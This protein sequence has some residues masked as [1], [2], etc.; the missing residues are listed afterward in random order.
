MLKVK[1]VMNFFY[2]FRFAFIGVAVV[3]AASIIT[4]DSLK[5]A[6]TDVSDF[7]VVYTYGE[8]ISY[9]GSAIMGNVTFEFRKAGVEDWSEEE[10]YLVGKY[11]ARARTQGN[12]GYKY[13]DISTFEIKPYPVTIKTDKSIDFGKRP[14]FDYASLPNG[15]ELN[16]K[17][18]EVTYADLTK[19]STVSSIDKNSLKVTS[20]DGKDVTYCYDFTVEDNNITF[21]QAPLI[22]NFK[23]DGM[24]T[25]TGETF[26]SNTISSVILDGLQVT[27]DLYYDAH[28]E[29]VSGKSISTIGSYTN[30]HVIRIVDDE[31]NDYTANYDYSINENH[32]NIE[33]APAIVVTSNS[34]EKPYDGQ[35][36][37]EFANPESLYSYNAEDLIP[38]HKLKFLGFANANKYTAGTYPNDFDF[39]IVDAITEEPVNRELYKGVRKQTG[40]LK[41]NRREITITSCASSA[42]F[43]NR[44]HSM[45]NVEPVD[46]PIGDGPGLVAGDEIVVNTT[47]M[48]KVLEP[49]EGTANVLTYTINRGGDD[50]TASYNITPIYKNIT[51]TVTPLKF[52]FIERHPIYDGGTHPYYYADGNFDVYDSI[53]RRENAALLDETFN[54]L[55]AGWAYDVRIPDSFRMQDVTDS[56]GYQATV[57]DVQI[58]IYDNS[59]PRIEVQKYYKL[60]TDITFDIPVSSIV[61]ANLTVTVEDYN[62]VFDNNSIASGIITNPNDP[63]SCV[64]YNGLA[65]TDTPNVEFADATSTNKDVGSYNLSMVFGVKRGT[66]N[67][68]NNYN[69]S[70]FNNKEVINANVTKRDILITPYEQNKFYNGSNKIDATVPGHNGVLGEELAIKPG[71]TFTLSDAEIGVH[72]FSFAEDDFT[73]KIGSQDVTDNYNIF[74]TDSATVYVMTRPISIS[75]NNKSAPGSHVY[76]DTKPH[77][78]FVDAN[79]KSSKEVNIEQSNYSNTS[80]LVSGHRIT[81][82][83]G[84]SIT[85]V[86]VLDLY[87]YDDFD[88][89]IYDENNVD[90]TSNYDITHTDFHIEVVESVITI[91]PKTISKA[92][93]GYPFEYEGLEGVGYN[94]FL[95]YQSPEMQK[96]YDVSFDTIDDEELLQPGHKL[97]L[98]K[99][100]QASAEAAVEGGYIYPTSYQYKVIDT[101][102][103]NNDVTSQYIIDAQQDISCLIVAKA[104]LKVNC[105]GGGKQYDGKVCTPPRSDQFVLDTDTEAAAYMNNIAVGPRFFER[106]EISAVFSTGVYDPSEMWRVGIYNFAIHVTI[107]DKLTHVVYDDDGLSGL[108][109]DY[110]KHYYDYTISKSK[111]VI[112][113]EYTSDGREL[114]RFTGTLGAN[115]SLWFGDEKWENRRKKYKDSNPLNSARVLKN[116][117]TDVSD[118]YE[119]T[120][121]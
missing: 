88:I 102:D 10:P 118:C 6:I 52:K 70:F 97:M 14:D 62:K 86:G 63:S 60:G 42:S 51:I 37:S 114:R 96:L 64:K 22:I 116:D 74:I 98:T 93:D 5:G 119:I 81:F 1:K 43:D 15:D 4:L 106:Y 50:V 61:K 59:N 91:T 54:S 27:G 67:V 92:Y 80:G 77:G 38:G 112:T 99:Y 115:D 100:S 113:T 121:S 66:Q 108:V 34:L 71:K 111:L 32:I 33:A 47:T 75:Y 110:N 21:N 84:L 85:N 78:V 105:I 87:S 29:V 101:N 83:S 44:Y 7:Q 79:G 25:Y 23:E 82:A 17:L 76:Y 16:E 94:D 72:H 19:R 20:K 104:T 40:S 48:T 24:H 73:I 26:S 57:N 49:T 68:T 12:R 56:N 95:D 58:T 103:G 18:V 11:E 109:I 31:G 3:T 69:I 35:A 28:V 55:P 53:D 2:R 8:P 117:L 90:V 120:F 39:D 46:A 65:S 36:F 45:P 89:H 9:T 41:I 13:S 107:E 30:E